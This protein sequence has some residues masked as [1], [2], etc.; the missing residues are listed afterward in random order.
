[1]STVP[2]ADNE[3]SYD[4]LK[5]VL[6]QLEPNFRFQLALRLPTIRSTEKA[7]PL[8]I[9]KLSFLDSGFHLNDAEYRLGVIR[10]AREGPTPSSIELKN[11]KGGVEFD[12]DRFGLKD[13]AKQVEITSKMMRRTA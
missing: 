3:L 4:S 1:M 8:H 11:Q 6:Q 10:Q 9:S 2:S 5:S 12:I 13:H 7:V